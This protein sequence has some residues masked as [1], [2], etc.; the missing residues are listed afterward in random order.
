[1]KYYA[2]LQLKAHMRNLGNEQGELFWNSLYHKL[3][4]ITN[5]SE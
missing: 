4:L 3:P 2:S 5:G 1:M